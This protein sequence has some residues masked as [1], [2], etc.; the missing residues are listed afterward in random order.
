MV[1]YTAAAAAAISN[2]PT[3]IQLAIEETNTRYANSNVAQRVRLV[4]PVVDF[5]IAVAAKTPAPPSRQPE[6]N[7]LQSVEVPM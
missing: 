7:R 4:L 3:E 1:V 2:V 6:E 5:E